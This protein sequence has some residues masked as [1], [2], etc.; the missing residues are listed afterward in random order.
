[1]S[2]NQRDKQICKSLYKLQSVF[3]RAVKIKKQMDKRIL[4]YEINFAVVKP[5]IQYT[6][7]N[8]GYILNAK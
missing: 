3:L 4:S 5:K 8:Q 2:E 1:M 7:Q 6:C